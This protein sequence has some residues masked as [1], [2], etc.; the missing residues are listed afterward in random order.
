MDPFD[1]IVWT[2]RDR[3]LSDGSIE[4][5]AGWSDGAVSIVASR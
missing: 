1:G 3:G 5:P 2:Q 4:A